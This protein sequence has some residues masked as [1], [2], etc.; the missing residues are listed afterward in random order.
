M[1]KE[2]E[3]LRAQRAREDERLKAALAQLPRAGQ[4]SNRN[5]ATSSG[6]RFNL[7]FPAGV[8]SRAL[9]PEY[10][11]AAL[12]PWI[13]FDGDQ[14]SAVPEESS[15]AP[16]EQSGPAN[17]QVS[18]AE[19][20]QAG[21][22]VRKGLT[23]PELKRMLGDPVKREPY[24]EGDLHVEILTFKRDQTMVEAT[25]VEGVLVRFREWSY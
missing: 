8:P 17:R 23:E 19:Q 25:M 12:K 9:N 6:S 11:I 18:N 24:I 7:V 1:E 10:V 20:T 3:D 13:D 5:R 2:L 15:S 16:R 4:D 22:E 14:R 21:T